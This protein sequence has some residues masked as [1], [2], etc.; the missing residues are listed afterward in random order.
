MAYTFD[1]SNFSCLLFVH[2]VSKK[3]STTSAYKDLDIKNLDLWSLRISFNIILATRCDIFLKSMHYLYIY[4]CRAGQCTWY[5]R[6]TGGGCSHTRICSY[7]INYKF[8]H[9]IFKFHKCS[10]FSIFSFSFCPYDEIISSGSVLVRV[11]S[12][13]MV[14]VL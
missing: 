14:L 5:D 7:I 2:R 9:N 1:I 10:L 11:L 8:I 13:G 3:R 12:I 6:H 4:I